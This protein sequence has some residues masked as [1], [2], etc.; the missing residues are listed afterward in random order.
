MSEPEQII[1]RYLLGELSESEQAALEEK[2]FTDPQAFNQMLK[3]ESELVDSYVRGQLSRRARERFEQS[4]L[5]HPRRRERVKFA[6]ALAS[7][8]DQIA[9]SEM[10]GDQTVAGTSLRQRLLV[11]LRGRRLALG[12]SIALALLVM[13]S[14]IWFFIENRRL[15]REL[16]ETQA[17]RADQEQRERELQQQREHELEQQVASERRRSEELTAELE[18]LQRTQ[19][20]T[21]QTASSPTSPAGPAFVSL[22]LTVGGARGPDNGRAQTLIIP[23]GTAQARIQLNLKEK[24]YPSYRASLQMVGGEE[25][26]SQEGIK[27]AVTK[28][29]ARF[30]LI[31]PADK[32][33]AGDYILTLR[34]V[35]TD[36]EID[37]VSKSIFRVEKR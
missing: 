12:L 26:Y 3:T 28:S 16:A 17:A 20:Q 29:G 18:R 15:R 27:P 4:Y 5:A 25:V 35:R 36:G 8:L 9:A 31:V 32:L 1:R 23:A 24:D 37:D 33:V 34:G 22:V 7:G 21:P 14:G 19:P 10:A 2:Y 30:V 13:M 11:S 6:D